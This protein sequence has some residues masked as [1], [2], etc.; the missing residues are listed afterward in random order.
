MF[1]WK[2]VGHITSH[3]SPMKSRFSPFSSSTDIFKLMLLCHLTL[4]ARSAMRNI[5]VLITFHQLQPGRNSL[6]A[7]CQIFTMLS[8]N[9][10]YVGWVQTDTLTTV[11]LSFNTFRQWQLPC[12]FPPVKHIWL[13]CVETIVIA[14][15]S[16]AEIIHRLKRHQP[17][18]FLTRESGRDNGETSNWMDKSMSCL[19]QMFC[20]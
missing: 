13:P 11:R 10:L 6:I 14:R 18:T 17:S 16:V 3:Q 5:S 1:V 4:F 12:F 2:N 15:W 19:F 20:L 9:T 7:K 8:H